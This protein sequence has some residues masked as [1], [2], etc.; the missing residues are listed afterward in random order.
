MARARVVKA[1]PQF[2]V[3]LSHSHE[4]AGWVKDL[5]GELTDDHRFNV[6]LDCWVLVPGS[7]SWQQEIVRGLEESS[8]CAVCLSGNT[9]DGWFKM[10]IELALNYQAANS[11]FRVLPVL[12]PGAPALIEPAFLRLK[13][14]ADFRQDHR[15]DEAMHVLTQGVRGLPAGRRTPRDGAVPKHERDLK[16]LRRLHQD[17]LLDERVVLEYQRKILATV[18]GK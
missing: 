2:D 9:P 14:W 13:T 16:E 6:W 18:F 3:F 10:E 11:N 17:G 1:R 4:D 12:L 5:A 7:L 8:T 15:R